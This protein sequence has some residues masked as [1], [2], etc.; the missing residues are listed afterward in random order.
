MNSDGRFFRV[1]DSSVDENG[2]FTVELIA[3]SG[4]GS[5]GGGGGSTVADLDLSFSN[6]SLLGSTYIYGKDSDIIFTPVS[7]AR[8]NGWP[9]GM[10]V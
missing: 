3:V 6:I 10:P 8:R 1:T 5:G 7:L 9:N 2:M 4:G